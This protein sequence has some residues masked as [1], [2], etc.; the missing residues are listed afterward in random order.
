MPIQW[1]G[2]SAV[3]NGLKNPLKKLAIISSHPIQ[4]NAPLFALMSENGAFE[5]RVFYTWGEDAVK[6]K[7]D[8]DFGKVIEW[9]IPLLK[10]YSYQFVENIAKRPG[11]HHFFGIDNLHLIQDI[12]NWGADVVWLWGWSFKSHLKAMRYFSGKIP[13]WFRGDSTLLDEAKGNTLKSILR[14]ALLKWIYRHID[15]AFYVG[16]NNKQYFLKFGLVDNQLVHAPHAVDVDRF[17]K[18][19]DEDSHRL[20]DWE[21]VLGIKEDDFVVLFAGK[22]EP[23]KNPLFIISLA[24]QLKSDNIKFLLVG[25]GILESEIKEA[26][27]L[28]DRIIVLPFQNQS[29]I[30]TT[31]RLGD[32]FVLPSVGP[33]ETWGLAMNEALAC[34]IPVFG[35]AMC[36]GSID[37]IDDNC[38]FVFNPSDVRLVAYK[39]NVLYLDKIRLKDMK[40]NALQYAQQF[41][42]QRV[43]EAVNQQ[44]EKQFVG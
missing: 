1:I 42:Y 34:G 11:S 18:W 24:N 43:L 25:N 15:M 13:V 16:E 10:G 35:S 22:F 21:S 32:V 14:R 17:T 29:V 40:R 27:T 28:D 31:Y 44:M 12:E 36:G 5:L 2:I 37:L 8:P 4:Y 9:D 26:A 3:K 41:H 6:P 30:P 19:N 39:L 7:F 23:K 38:G 33:G 20:K